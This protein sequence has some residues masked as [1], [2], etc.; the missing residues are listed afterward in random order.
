MFS[1]FEPKPACNGGADGEARRDKALTLLRVRRADL[2]RE[3]TAAALRVVL[4]RGEVCADDVRA[5]VAI[6]A[7]I[8]PK[9]VGVVFRDLA[10]AGI[11]RRVGFRKSNRPAAHARALSVWQLAE[12]AAALAWLAAHPPL[13]AD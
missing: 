10:D 5:L 13:T 8:S 11:L 1:L 2:I 3:C 9:L 6:P 7:D 4:D 12:G